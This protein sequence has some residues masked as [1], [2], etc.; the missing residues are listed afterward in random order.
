MERDILSQV[1]ALK[2]AKICYVIKSHLRTDTTIRKHL[3]VIKEQWKKL[4]VLETEIISVLHEQKID[5]LCVEKYS[6]QRLQL[7]HFHC[8]NNDKHVR[9]IFKSSFSD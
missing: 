2:L 7:D 3:I 1:S 8:S 4:N 9:I 5:P 6:N